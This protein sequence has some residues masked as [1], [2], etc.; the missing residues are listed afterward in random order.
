MVDS[1]EEFICTL[2]I[3]CI[4]V[5]LCRIKPPKDNQG[6]TPLHLQLANSTLLRVIKRLHFPLEVMLVRVRWYGAYPLSLRH[7]EDMMAERGVFVDH[8]T[9]RRWA[10]KILPVLAAVCCTRNRLVGG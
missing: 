4:V 2:R 5:W 10:W 8:S 6:M 7:L 9:V 1:L 3:M